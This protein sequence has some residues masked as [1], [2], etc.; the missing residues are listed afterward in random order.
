[1]HRFNQL[2][3]C[4]PTRNQSESVVCDFQFTQVAVYFEDTGMLAIW[5]ASNS[6]DVAPELSPAM[7]R[8]DE[9]MGSKMARYLVRVHMR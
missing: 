5:H 1:M 2:P 7:K 6:D 3:P 8:S 9:F 4:K